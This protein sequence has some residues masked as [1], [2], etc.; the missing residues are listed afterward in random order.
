MKILVKKATRYEQFY[1]NYKSKKYKNTS[2]Q[3]TSISMRDELDLEDT[4]KLNKLLTTK[5]EAQLD[6]ITVL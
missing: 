1:K 6:L 4:N 5:N 2:S 3:A